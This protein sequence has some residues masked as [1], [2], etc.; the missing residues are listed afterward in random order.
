MFLPGA[1]FWD[2]A[3]KPLRDGTPRAMLTVTVAWEEDSKEYKHTCYL[4]EEGGKAVIFLDGDHIQAAGDGQWQALCYERLKR[5][6]CECEEVYEAESE[7]SKRKRGG[8]SEIKEEPEQ[9]SKQRTKGKGKKE[10]KA[11]RGK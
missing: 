10:K 8:E 7:G 3:D 9:G 1:G 4:K 11:R 6:A 2:D 5:E